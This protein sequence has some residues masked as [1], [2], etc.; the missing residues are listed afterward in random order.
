M[1]NIIRRY[2]F[3]FFTV[4]AIAAL[5][6]AMFATHPALAQTEGEGAHCEILSLV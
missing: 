6:L 2:N 3:N 4:I 5:A 1:M